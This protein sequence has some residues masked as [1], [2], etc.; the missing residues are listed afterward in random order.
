MHEAFF[1]ASDVDKGGVEALHYFLH[2]AEVDVTD[3]ILSAGFLFV[4]FHQF[5]V[6]EQSYLDILFA[7]GYN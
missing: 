1:V 6:F 7:R 2:L 5:F 3:S 4:Q